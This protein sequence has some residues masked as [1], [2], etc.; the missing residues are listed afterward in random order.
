MTPPHGARLALMCGLPRSG[1]STYARGL[2]EA[3]YVRL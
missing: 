3:G 2:Q 1:K